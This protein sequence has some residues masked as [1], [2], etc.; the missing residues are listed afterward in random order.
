MHRKTREIPVG[1]IVT[2]TLLLVLVVAL[3]TGLSW[4]GSPAAASTNP[5]M[6]EPA[7]SAAAHLAT[8][9]PFAPTPTGAVPVTWAA[10][11]P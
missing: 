3:L 7:A 1:E 11:R 6:F 2:F 4:L 9:E 10:T 5:A 8:A